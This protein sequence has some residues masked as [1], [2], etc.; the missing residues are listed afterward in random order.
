MKTIRLTQNQVAFVDDSD[1]EFL[2][3]WRWCAVWMKCTR[4][5]YAVRRARIYEGHQNGT[6]IWMH[7]QI[8]GLAPG[9]KRQGDHA[10]RHT[11][12]NQR[13]NLRV[14]TREQ[15]SANQR[16][17][18]DSRTGLKGVTWHKGQGIYHARIRVARKLIHLGQFTGKHEAHAAYC[19]AAIKYFGEFARTA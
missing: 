11:L 7:R 10:N 13:S 17:S 4:S 3:Q 9:D 5:Y 15:Q 8:L 16:L 6:R 18:R 12:D 2:S 19:T 14:A 1:Y